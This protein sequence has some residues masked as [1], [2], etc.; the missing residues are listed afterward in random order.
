MSEF[1]YNQAELVMSGKGEVKLGDYKPKMIE[2]NNAGIYHIYANGEILKRLLDNYDE[3][4][5]EYVEEHLSKVDDEYLIYVGISSNIKSRISDHKSGDVV[6]SAFCRSISALLLDRIADKRDDKDAYKADK[7]VIRDLVR[8]MTIRYKAYRYDPTQRR[9]AMMQMARYEQFTLDKF[10]V[11]FNKL[12][13][14][15]A[16]LEPFIFH[17]QDISGMGK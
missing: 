2:D 12:G 1:V 14:L 4:F 7:E 15:S 9:S 6:A 5:F 17:M 13:N 8:S 11:P 16:V 10:H 3:N